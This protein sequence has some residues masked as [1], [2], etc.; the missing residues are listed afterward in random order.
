[1]HR[2]LKLA[3]QQNPDESTTWHALGDWMDEDGL[4]G[5]GVMRAHA[6]H[7]L[8][9]DPVVGPGRWESG[10]SF[11]HAH[12]LIRA[13]YR[14]HVLPS[15]HWAV[16][17]LTR[18][19]PHVRLPGV[20]V[21]RYLVGG[22]YRHGLP[23]P[24]RAE[25]TPDNAHEV[26]ADA[27]PEVR[28]AAKSALSRAYPN[29]AHKLARTNF[30]F[31]QVRAGIK[32]E[33]EHTDDPHV[34][35]KIALDHLRE[36]PRY[37]TKL[38]K[39]KL[40]REAFDRVVAEHG[41]DDTN[42]LVY[43]DWL[44]EHGNDPQAAARI[45]WW[46]GARAAMRDAKP[47]VWP[48][49]V[50][51][52]WTVLNFAHPIHAMWSDVPEWVQRLGV[53]EA[54]RKVGV[55]HPYQHAVERRALGLP[56]DNVSDRVPATDS[57]TADYWTQE[58]L[59]NL[60]LPQGSI[61]ATRN[62]VHAADTQQVSYPAVNTA[63][64]MLRALHEHILNNPPPEGPKKLAR[65]KAPAGGMVVNNRFVPGGRFTERAL[66]RIRD[67]AAR[68]FK[69]SRV[70]I[71]EGVP[72]DEGQFVHDIHDESGERIGGVRVAPQ[73]EALR[74]KF[75]G[76]KG[77]SDD[78]A[79]ALGPAAVRDAM[80][81]L[82]RLYPGVKRLTGLRV[83]GARHGERDT[84]VKMARRS[85][86]PVGSWEHI[87]A[88][89]TPDPTTGRFTIEQLRAIEDAHGLPDADRLS[90]R[91][92][93]TDKGIRTRLPDRQR[94]YQAVV[95]RALARV[96]GVKTLKSFF[97]SAGLTKEKARHVL[98]VLTHDLA[99]TR[100]KP[101][102]ETGW[103]VGSM[104]VVDRTLHRM[105][106]RGKSDPLW[107][108]LNAD[109]QL[110][111]KHAPWDHHP[112]VVL[113]KL[114]TAVQSASAEPIPNFLS[115]YKTWREGAERNPE[116]PVAG[117][118]TR[119]VSPT[120][121][122]VRRASAWHGTKIPDM[123]RHP[124]ARARWYMRWFHPFAKD[125]HPYSG[126]KAQVIDMPNHPDHGQLVWSDTG[127]EEGEGQTFDAGLRAKAAGLPTADIVL[128]LPFP[129]TRKIGGEYP[130]QESGPLRPVGHSVRGENVAVS[131]DR[132]KKVVQAFREPGK[133]V[134]ETYRDA[135]RWLLT[136][137]TKTE[138]RQMED[139]IAD[140]LDPEWRG[141]GKREETLRRLGADLNRKPP[142][143]VKQPGAFVFGP[144]FGPFFMNQN[145]NDPAVERDYGK[146]VTVD[147][148]NRRS[149]GRAT[150]H[151]LRPDG[152]EIGGP[153][154]KERSLLESALR[155]IGEH[156]GSAPANVQADLWYDEKAND[157]AFGGNT[158]MQD[159]ADGA[160]RAMVLHRGLP[161]LNP[162][163]VRLA[164]LY[165]SPSNR[166][167]STFA[168]AFEGAAGDRMNELVRMTPGGRSGYGVWKDGAEETRVLHVDGDAESAA[169]RLGRHFGQKQVLLFHDDPGGPDALHVFTIHDDDP[170]RIH[171]AALAH[172]IE[173]LTV[174]P[175]GPGRSQVHVVILGGGPVELP[176][177]A[178]SVTRG[179][180][181]FRDTL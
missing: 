154:G 102:G 7:L 134:A 27:P 111:G 81:Q 123:P 19:H 155:T 131:I 158:N 50:G 83:S 53:V 84:Q 136:E 101:G 118:A 30:D 63:V 165:V 122:F 78:R 179:R 4:P 110:K 141:K 98:S 95:R 144:K 80:R 25:L 64:P 126:V 40:S 73:G 16:F 148:W 3:I 68:K 96:H 61:M 65:E 146:H 156:V 75:V 26:L 24:A 9:G 42:W 166:E 105:F 57:P 163:V 119:Q 14:E 56:A 72:A 130:L 157:N 149:G 77:L 161:P 142:E 108:E 60:S 164:R 35:L 91:A 58:H 140:S 38:K 66:K 150:G 103:Y 88:G 125:S 99:R 59:H 44:E 175:D 18:P 93:E 132:L 114:L 29:V 82:V 51:E 89:M 107:G 170:E 90:A 34:A 178:H 177:A 106:A 133:S 86:A 112:A 47:G 37:Y 120:D 20:V 117:I 69:L 162:R 145:M 12:E 54:A 33:R 32:V 11:Y 109:G 128:P 167:G 71:R 168:Q 76:L 8:R 104:N 160:R 79:N 173:H 6:D 48:G 137:H 139:R 36:D 180:A 67:V 143:H 17:S 45:R 169:D 52:N 74:V 94:F 49:Q 15:L 70:T 21:E 124:E 2:E 46:V 41:A 1:M 85:S 121:S 138:F 87:T 135:A 174:L 43:A 55:R 176:A 97:S 5:G 13:H 10:G 115:A 129:A 171:R 113:F 127:D 28:G 92:V 62:A 153:E 39:L 22:P 172:G 100:A 181:E 116:D 152:G 151:L 23:I 159:F 31:D 147:V